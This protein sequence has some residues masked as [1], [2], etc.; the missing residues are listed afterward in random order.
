MRRM[1]H[2]RLQR[3]WSQVVLAYKA[4]VA[5]ADIS[6]I[7]TGRGQPYPNQRKRLARA[8]R[9]DPQTLLDEVSDSSTPAA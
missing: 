1:K 6:R 9:L 5:V 2:E 3:G 7:E 4:K 8:L